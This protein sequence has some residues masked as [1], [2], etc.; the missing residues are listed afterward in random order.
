MFK[1]ELRVRRIGAGE[2]SACSN[3]SKKQDWIKYLAM[4]GSKKSECGVNLHR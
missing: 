1:F 2:D 3:Y 4:S